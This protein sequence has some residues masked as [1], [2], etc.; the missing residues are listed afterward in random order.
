MRLVWN[1]AARP[2]ALLRMR[3]SLRRPACVLQD[4]VSAS[5][6][7]AKIPRIRGQH[8]HAAGRHGHVLLR[9]HSIQ[10]AEHTPL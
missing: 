9:S 5:S 7:H 1:V 4:S 2:S 10:I 6:E 3:S 8:V